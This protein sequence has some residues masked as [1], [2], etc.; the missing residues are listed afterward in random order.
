MSLCRIVAQTDRF[1]SRRHV[2]ARGEL[3]GVVVVTAPAA[4]KYRLAV[5][6]QIV[7]NAEARLIEQRPCRE[8][9]ER[10]VWI[11]SCATRIRNTE[12]RVQL[13]LYLRRIENRVTVTQVVRPR[14]ESA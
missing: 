8:S 11:T 3:A 9:A 5:A 6:E 10:Y 14:S 1:N 4:A 13:V 7:S 2:Q 12:S